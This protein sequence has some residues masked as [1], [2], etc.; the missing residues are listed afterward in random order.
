MSPSGGPDGN[1][2]GPSAAPDRAFG[3]GRGPRRRM[4]GQGGPGQ[5]IGSRIG[6]PG[7]RG[8]RAGGT[9][10]PDA[11]REEIEAGFMAL[12]N[13]DIE[14]AR[15]MFIVLLEGDP[16]IAMAHVGIGRIFA[17]EGDH[18]RGIEHFNEALRLQ[19]DLPSAQFF[20]A[21]A[22]EALGEIDDAAACYDAV[23]TR[24]PA[25]G[26]AYMRKAQMLERAGR[27]AEAAE[28]LTAAIRRSPQDARLRTALAG[29][30]SR[31]GDVER[32][33]AEYRRAIDLQP[34]NWYSHFGLGTMHLRAGSFAPARDA[35]EKAARIAPDQAAVQQALGAAL[36]GMGDHARALAAYEKALAVDATNLR[37]VVGAA[38]AR[39]ALG[40]HEAAL[41]TLLGAGRIGQRFPPLQKALG[42]VYLAMDRLQEAVDTYRAL[43]LNTPRMGET[44]PAIVALADS[45]GDGDM[46]AFARSLQEALS[47]QIGGTV[48]A[49]RSNPLALRERLRARRA[50]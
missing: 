45:E 40:Q 10:I 46:G 34:D 16:G 44:N 4:P 31:V 7:R 42:D 8:M 49:L 21:E 19:P 12:Q 23:I 33:S 35:L 9:P 47:T 17:L 41:S 25:R 43:I 11:Y 5:A 26:F 1:G 13:G 20:A 3:L 37:S 28:A 6:D 36:T 39:L 24:D 48:D 29:M 27:S 32:G 15:E 50:P 2:A 14:G 38:L 18:A 22:F 30:L